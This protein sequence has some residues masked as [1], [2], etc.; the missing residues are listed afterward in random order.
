[1]RRSAGLA[2]ADG[3][4][5]LLSVLV[6]GLTY[7]VVARQAGFALLEISATSWIIFAGA[8][9]FVAIE[10]LR[11]GAGAG[12]VIIAAFLINLRHLLMAT[13]L[14]RHFADRPLLQRLGIGYI[15]TD[16]AFAMAVGWYRRG[17]R[18][19]AYYVFF[20]A[21]LWLVWNVATVVGA[22]ASDRIAEPRRLGVDFAIT[23]SFLSIVALSVRGRVDALVALIAAGAAAALALAGASLVAVIGAG[24]LAPL[25]IFALP[26]GDRR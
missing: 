9:Q 26:R 5:I 10:L 12:T 23:A 1:M 3:W 16:E 22:L 4:P 6:V 8:S 17:G 7:G 21:A 18:G 15:L 2:L 24:A 13:A 11:G 14:R 19:V 25:A 20:G